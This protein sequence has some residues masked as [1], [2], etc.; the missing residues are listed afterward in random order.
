MVDLRIAAGA[1]LSLGAAFGLTATAQAADYTVDRLD[2][3]APASACLVAVPN[4]CSLRQA[5]SN[6][7]NSNR[8]TVDRVLFQAGLSGTITLSGIEGLRTTEPLD[9]VGPGARTLSVTGPDL[10]SA[11]LTT[12]QGAG[13]DPVNIS[14]LTLTGGDA[15]NGNGGA[16]YSVVTDLTIDGVTISHNHAADNRE[17]GGIEASSNQLTIKN[18]TIS[19]NDGG[20]GGGLHALDVKVGIQ[21]STI[22]GNTA[23]GTDAGY[24]YGGGIWLS[25]GTAG[26]LVIYESTIADNHARYGG[27]ISAG[28]STMGL[29][30]TVVANNTATGQVDLRNAGPDP[31]KLAHS[32]VELPAVGSTSDVTGFAGSNIFGVDP[33]L[34]PLADNG[35]A[36][37]TEK[38]SLTSP[39]LDKGLTMV[40]PLVDQRG[41][42][43][44]FDISSIANTAT[45]DAADIG[46]VEL[47]AADFVAPAPPAG[48]TAPA[49]RKKKCK[50][51]HKRSAAAAKKCKKKR[52]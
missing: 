38:P 10:T 51:K 47:Q 50:K 15:G 20:N 41:V 34:G 4:D 1:G 42:P 48:P 13:G 17:G 11:I 49:A 46:A 19:D 18:S 8:P 16:I 39:L 21:N 30:D 45:G 14:G 23:S 29:G 22:S 28:A 26:N 2:D 52:R 37:N 3:P 27:G 36:T 31:F 35:G 24:G 12:E 40:A 43:R 25:Q 7:Q 44:P 5:I 9:I 6:T 32:L 33:Q